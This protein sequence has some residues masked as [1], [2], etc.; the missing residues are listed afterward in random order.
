MNFFVQQESYF[1]WQDIL[2]D[3]EVEITKLKKQLKEIT[4]EKE[5]LKITIVGLK[6]KLKVP[7]QST[8]IFPSFCTQSFKTKNIN[9]FR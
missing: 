8:Y 4:K 3:K 7:F 9:Q 6:V 2:D 1:E 5:K